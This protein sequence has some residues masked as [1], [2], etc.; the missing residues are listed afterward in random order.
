MLSR[1]WGGWCSVRNEQLL[2]SS[3]VSWTRGCC[4]APLPSTCFWL[5]NSR[6]VYH[7]KDIVP[8]RFF[9]TWK[10]GKGLKALQQ[11]GLGPWRHTS[12]CGVKKAEMTYSDPIFIMFCCVWGCCSLTLYQTSPSPLSTLPLDPVYFYWAKLISH[13]RWELNTTE[14]AA[15]AVVQPVYT[16]NERRHEQKLCYIPPEVFR[17]FDFTDFSVF[18]AFP[19]HQSLTFF[20]S[21]TFYSKSLPPTLPC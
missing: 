16:F 11:A 8:L 15:Q 1:E 2:P 7:A 13:K 9:E 17:Q 4:K 10:K 21:L 14:R 6:V 3:G 20:C 12:L 19:F 18:L 5:L